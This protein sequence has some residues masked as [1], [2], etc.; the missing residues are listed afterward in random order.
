[1]TANGRAGA[2]GHWLAPGGNGRGHRAR[3]NRAD[4]EA[5]EARQLAAALWGGLK[6]DNQANSLA[7]SLGCARFCGPGRF[8]SAAATGTPNS[9]RGLVLRAGQ[10]AAG[11]GGGDLEGRPRCGDSRSPPWAIRSGNGASSKEAARPAAVARRLWRRFTGGWAGTSVAPRACLALLTSREESLGLLRLDGLV[12]LIISARLERPSRCSSS[13]PH[14]AFPC[15]GHDD[16]I[17]PSI[18]STG[19]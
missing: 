11:G 1:V 14:P 3:P 8:R 10:R 5:A 16:G 17:L 18:T 7:A 12:D 2:G 9:M 4:L 19:R 15:S 6:A 13:G